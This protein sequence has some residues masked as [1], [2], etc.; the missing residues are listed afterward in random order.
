M[1]SD[2]L[3]MSGAIASGPVVGDGCFNAPER[4]YVLSADVP[5]TAEMLVAAV[6][7]ARDDLFDF[8]I[9]D[10]DDLWESIT[11]ALV[12]EGFYRLEERALKIREE[13]RSGT[14]AA[15]EWLALCR[16]RVADIISDAWQAARHR[17]SCGYAAD[18][19]TAFAGHLR[20]AEGKEPEH[21]RVTESGS[22]H[23]FWEREPLLPRAVSLNS[24]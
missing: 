19:A 9:A 20:M 13:Q 23:R 15:P 7:G 21:R 16:R 1:R 2:A 3:A 10:D 4:P 11:F 12:M 6:Y 18:D 8:D 5:M 24:P 22:I 14:L 17:C